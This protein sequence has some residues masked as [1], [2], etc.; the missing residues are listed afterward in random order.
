MIIYFINYFYSNV[1]I[2]LLC[3]LKEFHY[4]SYHVNSSYL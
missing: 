4:F 3:V 1:F 2:L